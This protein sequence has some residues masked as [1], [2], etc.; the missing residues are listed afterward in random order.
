MRLGAW[1]CAVKASTKLLISIILKIFLRH[2]H[3]YEFNSDYTSDFEAKDFIPSG[4][5]PET[6]LV[7]ALELKSHPFYVGVQYHPEYKSTVANPH[8]L[9]KALVE[10]AVKFQTKIIFKCNK[11]MV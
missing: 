7:E 4:K 3:R 11:I 2:R 8:P 9:F 5:N 10:A 1:K 6:G